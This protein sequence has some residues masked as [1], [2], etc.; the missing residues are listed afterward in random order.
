MTV[1]YSCHIL[2]FFVTLLACL[3]FSCSNKILLNWKAVIK[4]YV[5]VCLAGLY[6]NGQLIEHP[7]CKPWVEDTYWEIKRSNNAIIEEAYKQF[8]GKKFCTAVLFFNTCVACD[9]TS[10]QLTCIVFSVVS[11]VIFVRYFSFYRCSSWMQTP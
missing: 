2:Q 11:D 9:L 6:K 1:V 7:D 5:C 3:M 8:N 10:C 4:K